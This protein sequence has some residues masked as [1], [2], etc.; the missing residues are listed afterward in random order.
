[1]IFLDASFIVAYANADD[2]H[3]K[4][5]VELTK[6]IENGMHGERAVSE[7]ILDEV[8]TV[9]LSRT[10]NYDAAVSTG[11]ELRDMFF[12]REDYALLEKTWEIFSTQNKPHISFTDCNT[13]AICEREGIAK[14]ATFDEQLGKKSGLVIVK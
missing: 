14:L 2:R 3:H 13:I 5:A 4:R 12:I 6:E 7:Y 1:M 8:V 10:N 9:L 11:R